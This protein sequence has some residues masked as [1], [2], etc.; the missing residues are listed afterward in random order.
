MQGSIK[1]VLFNLAMVILLLVLIEAMSSLI[2]SMKGVPE[3]RCF[4]IN[5]KYL[6]NPGYSEMQRT[7]FNQVD[8]LLGYS[9]TNS[10]LEALGFKAERGTVVFKTTEDSI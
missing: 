5:T 2:L 1:L 7:Q 9:K 4:L 8:P 6:N 3:E 10:Q